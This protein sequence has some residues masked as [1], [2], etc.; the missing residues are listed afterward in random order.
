M[1]SIITSIDT[2]STEID[3]SAYTPQLIGS[4]TNPPLPATIKNVFINGVPLVT[5]GDTYLS[6]S[7][8]DTHATPYVM[9]SLGLINVF[10]NGLEVAVLGSLLF[11]CAVNLIPLIPS[12]VF[13]NGPNPVP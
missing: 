10:A 7:A 11:E 8:G 5:Q 3:E 9:P 12:N 13:A 6:H 1:P 2:I 4:P